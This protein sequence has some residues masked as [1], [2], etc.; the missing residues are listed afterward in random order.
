MDPYT[1]RRGDVWEYTMATGQANN[2]AP[3][4]G[5]VAT[6]APV[7]GWQ[8][9]A[10]SVVSHNVYLGTD[11]DVVPEA[12]TASPHYKGNFAEPAFEP[13]TLAPAT[14]YYWRV[15]EVG[16]TYV[17]P[18]LLG[19]DGAV[20]GPVWTFVTPGYALLQVDFALPYGGQPGDPSLVNYWPDTGKEGWTIWPDQRWW[21]LY[22]HDWV[23]YPNIGETG[24]N[25][26]VSTVYDGEAGIKVNGMCMENKAGGGTQ[27]Y[28]IGDPIA[29]SW[30]YQVD[31]VNP[32][33]ASIVLALAN[34][35]PG[36]YWVTSYHNYW[37]PQSS[38]SRECT[39][40]A[41]Q[42]AEHPMPWV[43]AMSFQEALDYYDCVDNGSNCGDNH[44]VVGAMA[45]FTGADSETTGIT[46]LLEAANVICTSTTSDSEVGTSLVKFITDGSP[47]IIA[48][49]AATWESSSQYI[50]GRAVLN[51]FEI[52]AQAPVLTA[53][54]PDP[55]DGAADVEPSAELTW[56]TGAMAVSHEVYFGTDQAGVGDGTAAKVT[57]PRGTETLERPLILGETY[58][59][60]VDE[61]GA[62][63]MV[64]PGEVWSFATAQ[65]TKIEDFEGDLAWEVVG[66]AWVESWTEQ[67]RNGSA[68][69]QLQYYNRSP[70][71][72]SGAAMTFGEAQS[73]NGFEG[74][75]FYYKGEAG[76]QD[77]KVYVVI[78]DAGGN[79]STVVSS[80]NV[81]LSDTQWQLWSAELTE[82]GGVD[83]GN[84]TKIEIGVGEPGGSSS[85]AVGNLYIDD[86]G[87]CGGGPVPA[88]CA[89]PG[90]LNNDTQVDLEDL[91]AVA[92]ILLDAGAPFI[93]QVEA[94]HCGDLNEDEQVDLD[95]LQAVAG[96]LLDAGSPFIALC[97]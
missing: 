38:A 59:W 93:V 8:P 51:A 7:L 68:S 24:I 73:F 94:R 48:Y 18:A 85:G 61:V 9:G 53:G 32:P 14:R 43:K 35:P 17:V 92:G 70:N 10:G 26:A 13:G 79:S 55:A 65:C 45:G 6:A 27:V 82:F 60:R 75:G 21:D 41:G 89:C 76:N 22:M 64:W 25:A 39:P 80:A 81:S 40:N 52:Q 96:I 12:T 67:S 83:L 88:G 16:E 62:D 71:V 29:N 28:P 77:D 74:F 19:A 57:L 4:D 72:S 78:E 33:S 31:H 95:D 30:L 11:P 3:G 42:G 34:L 37:Q 54:R 46:S 58:Y 15:D 49:E 69:M 50:G 56:L 66:G 36:E 90:D 23:V 97:P 84:V 20:K 1:T 86:V 87:L 91:Q 2:P 63:G 44:S 47:V 5:Q